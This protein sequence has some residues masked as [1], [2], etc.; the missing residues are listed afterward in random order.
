MRQRLFTALSVLLVLAGCSGD[1]TIHFGAVLPV[2]G[3]AA[4]YGESVR[5]GVELAFE[6]IQA[7]S[8][9]AYT[10]DL[11]IVDSG[12]D[13]AKAAELLRQL[14]EEGALAVIGGV[15]TAEALEMVSVADEADR[16]LLSPSASSPELTGI[17]R[18]FFRVFFSD[19]REGIKMANFAVMQAGLKTVVILAKEE[20]WAAG[21]QEIF[22]KEFAR[23]GGEVLDVL[24]FPEG[25]QD[26]SGL[27]ERVNTL[28]P[29][30][31]Y[32]A[33]YAEDVAA[34]VEQIRASGYKGRILTTHAFASPT[35]L[36]RV[37]EPARGVLLTAP[38][39]KADSD[40]EPIKSFVT[41]YGEKYNDAPDVWSAHGYDAMMVLV[42]AIPEKFRTP[43]DFRS[44]LKSTDDYHGVAGNIRFD[45]K[46]DVGKFPHVY[47]VT[48]EGLRD[49][50]IEVSRDREALME[51]LRAL[52]EKR[53]KAQMEQGRN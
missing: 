12:S 18:N 20:L 8:D 24:E 42:E 39:F 45:E 13:P 22:A 47:Q 53:R 23:N 26:F 36:E 3:S 48:T 46:G 17:S 2:T 21:V 40:G 10:F 16:V 33:A 30:A 28:E 52:R 15:T 51:Q 29:A 27:V 41:A 43:S 34:L 4:I 32:L 44:G 49:Y 38:Q 19:F 5:R 31:V 35:I 11:K 7:R 1:E 25:T 37:G 50:E 14:Y 6:H 9:S